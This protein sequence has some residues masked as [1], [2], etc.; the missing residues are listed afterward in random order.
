[1]VGVLTDCMVVRDRKGRVGEWLVGC[2]VHCPVPNDLIVRA[3]VK[4]L[5][6]DQRG[7]DVFEYLVDVGRKSSL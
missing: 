2:Y 6:R 1:M 3:L 7:S 5:L 4:V